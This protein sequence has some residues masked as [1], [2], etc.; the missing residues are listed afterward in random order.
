[1][2]KSTIP[3][4][5]PVNEH[6]VDEDIQE[7]QYF[8]GLPAEKIVKCSETLLKVLCAH[9]QPKTIEE[10]MVIFW[11]KVTGLPDYDMKMRKPELFKWIEVQ[12]ENTFE[13]IVRM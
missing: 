7:Y 6:K 3:L 5:L 10:Y 12:I 2:R 9:K 4:V 11:D 1:D 8:L 13:D